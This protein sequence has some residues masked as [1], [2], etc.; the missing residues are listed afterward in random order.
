[1]GILINNIL[2]WQKYKSEMYQFETK[3]HKLNIILT[4]IYKTVPR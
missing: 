3:L 2:Y 1:M 4:A